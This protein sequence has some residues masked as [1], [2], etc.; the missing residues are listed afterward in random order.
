MYS[1]HDEKECEGFNCPE[2]GKPDSYAGE[3]IL[4]LLII[5]NA[6]LLYW[7]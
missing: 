3:V 4:L 5:V 6:I 7:R 2:H 1:P